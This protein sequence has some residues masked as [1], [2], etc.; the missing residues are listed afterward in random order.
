MKRK[1]LWSLLI[2]FTLVVVINA[3]S[4]WHRQPVVFYE[5]VIFPIE[6]ISGDIIVLENGSSF[7]IDEDKRIN[8]ISYGTDTFTINATVKRSLWQLMTDTK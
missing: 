7:V 6:V 5:P 2:V 8:S 1:I 4:P 3:W